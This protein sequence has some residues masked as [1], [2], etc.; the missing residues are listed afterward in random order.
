MAVA[1]H[2]AGHLGLKRDQTLP[3]QEARVPGG[4]GS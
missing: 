3:A 1:V 2:A 4:T